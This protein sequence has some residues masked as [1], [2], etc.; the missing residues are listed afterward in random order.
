MENTVSGQKL[1]ETVE[2]VSMRM[3]G[4]AESLFWRA[5]FCLAG[6][7]LVGLACGA[8]M[9]WMKARSNRTPPTAT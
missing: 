5:F 6:L 3:E 9:I 8:V 1:D 2:D 7:V 4:L